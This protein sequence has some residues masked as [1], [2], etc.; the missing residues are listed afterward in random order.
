VAGAGG[1]CTIRHHYDLP[2]AEHGITAHSGA[3]VTSCGHGC[4]QVEYDDPGSGHHSSC[5]TCVCLPTH[6]FGFRIAE[7]DRVE[8]IRVTVAPE[9]T[10]FDIG[11][12]WDCKVDALFQSWSIDFPGYSAADRSAANFDPIDRERITDRDVT[13]QMRTGGRFTV[14]NDYRLLTDGGRWYVAQAPFRVTVRIEL[15][16]RPLMDHGRAATPTTQ[17]ISPTP[18][19]RWSVT[20][21]AARLGRPVSRAPATRMA[22]AASPNR[23]MTAASPPRSPR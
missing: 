12:S 6:R 11:C 14:G 7:P 15:A 8:R 5:A 20:R 1:S 2:P 13:A 9:R 22:S 16:P 18:A 23:A 21:T 17:A 4:V 19:N 3:M 10:D